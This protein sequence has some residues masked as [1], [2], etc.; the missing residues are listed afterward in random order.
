MR[1]LPIEILTTRKLSFLTLMLLHRP[2]L[3]VTN[4]IHDLAR[5]HLPCNTILTHLPLIIR[6]KSSGLT[7]LL[8]FARNLLPILSQPSQVP[9]PRMIVVAH[10]SS[11]SRNVASLST[12]ASSSLSNVL[13]LPPLPAHSLPARVIP[14]SQIQILSSSRRVSISSVAG[15]ERVK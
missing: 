9:L 12:A 15:V 3:F 5:I 6:R 4:H 8:S 13:H 11:P 2:M 10:I 14:V 1:Q 7:V